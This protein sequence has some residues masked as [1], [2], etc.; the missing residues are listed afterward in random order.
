MA[1]ITPTRLLGAHPERPAQRGLQLGVV[2]RLGEELVDGPFV[3]GVEHIWHIE[4]VAGGS[5]VFTL[6]PKFITEMWE[7]DGNLNFQPTI[8]DEVPTKVME[9]LLRVPYFAEAYE[10]EMD[11]NKYATIAPMIFTIQEFSK[12]TNKMV[13][14]VHERIATVR[15]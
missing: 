12:A 2:P 3:D 9:K 10:E 4:L 11:P 5:M 14:F 8:E 15:G 7:L 13:D 1:R 6:P